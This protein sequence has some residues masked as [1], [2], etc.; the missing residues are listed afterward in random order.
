MLSRKIPIYIYR[1]H[2]CFEPPPQKKKKKKKKHYTDFFK[3]S[4]EYFTPKTIHAKV[5]VAWQAHPANMQL[6]KIRINW[7]NR[8]MNATIISDVDFSSKNIIEIWIS[9]IGNLL[10]QWHIFCMMRNR[11]WIYTI[12]TQNN[13]MWSRVAYLEGRANVNQW[14]KI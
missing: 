5:A 4:L 3:C 14:L 12:L 10:A 1:N 2:N 6:I 9:W 11:V 7:F 8:D 13:G